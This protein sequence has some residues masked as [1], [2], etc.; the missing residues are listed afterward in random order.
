MK[1]SRYRLMVGQTEEENRI[2][3][4]GMMSDRFDLLL[5]VTA[6]SREGVNLTV[7]ASNSSEVQGTQISS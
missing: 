4:A 6:H 7:E 5:G 1:D 3:C 2:C